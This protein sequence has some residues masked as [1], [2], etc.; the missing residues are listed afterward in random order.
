[1][2]EAQDKQLGNFGT[3]EEIKQQ[4]S[5]KGQ[6]FFSDSTM[7]FFGS[8]VGYRVYGG[9]YFVTSEKDNYGDQ[10]RRYTVR[11]AYSDGD[12]DTMGD[13]QAFATRAQAVAYARSL[14]AA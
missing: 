2:S 6:H 5:R 7:R 14:V 12:I 1:M 11:V 3:I 9:C 8:R 13:F 10:A 4:N